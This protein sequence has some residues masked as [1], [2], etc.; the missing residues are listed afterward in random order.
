[1]HNFFFQITRNFLNFLAMAPQPPCLASRLYMKGN[2]LVIQTGDSMYLNN[3]QSIVMD[4]LSIFHM[5]SNGSNLNENP[6]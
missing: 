4:I 6:T 1:M 3:N 2:D 5:D